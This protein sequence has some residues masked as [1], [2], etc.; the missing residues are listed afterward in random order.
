MSTN[1]RQFL[2]TA[3]V[4]TA[5]S[6][7]RILGANERIRVGSIGT[8]HRCEYLLG[9][10]KKCEAE[11]VAVCDVYTPH[12]AAAKAKHELQAA[13]DK[14][15]RRILDRKDIDAVIIGAPD[16]WHVKM[17]V[18][19]IAAG[20]DV[21][22]E[23]P[24]THTLEEGGMLENAVS[25]SKQVVQTGTQQRSWPHF[26]Q[27]REL[28]TSG[29]LGKITLIQ[30]YWYQNYLQER[31]IPA[32]DLAQLDWKSW[33]GSAPERS[34]D[35]SRWR[36]WR[37]YW[38]YGGGALTDLFTHWVDVVHWYTGRDTPHAAQA[39]GNQ[40]IRPEWDCPDTITAS[41]RY[42]DNFNVVY[43]GTLN[44]DLDGGGLIF[45]GSKGVLRLNRNGF[46]FWAD[47][48]KYNENLGATLATQEA[49]SQG[50]GTF[51]HM[52]NFL[53]CVK[54]RQTPNAPVSVG[55]AAARAGHL[56][57]LALRSGRILPYPE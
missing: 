20:K 28:M 18:D 26:M 5:L 35:A 32:V 17:T 9:L 49:K 43:M 14:D 53:D 40:Y 25:A 34:F 52:R 56:G 16:H 21:Y 1:R 41:F 10:A 11:I 19:A 31:V 4:A 39:I 8:G 42:P 38:D 22:V 51:D 6:R 48:H 33:L 50:D 27:A 23:K 13:E 45:R 2:Q 24:V 36:M 57:N 15:Y 54:S 12:M 47:E 7:G 46:W 44:S 55:I 3:T 29:A 37:W 30:T